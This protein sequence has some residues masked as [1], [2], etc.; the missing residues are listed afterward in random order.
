MAHQ[1][2]TEEIANALQ[3]S[4]WLATPITQ[5]PSIELSCWSVWAIGEK[6]YFVG[7]NETE[8]EG[9]VSSAIRGIDPKTLRGVTDSGRT[10][11]LLGEPGHDP[12]GM[13]IWQIILRN[14]RISTAEDVTALVMDRIASTS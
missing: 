7:Y 12:D 10:Y 6:Y 3:T 2:I 11:Q 14:S 5:T 8:R 9:R 13:Y 1:P 4:V